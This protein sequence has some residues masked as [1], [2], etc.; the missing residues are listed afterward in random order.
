MI[1]ILLAAL[2]VSI[3]L[4]PAAR[5]QGF[6]SDIKYSINLG[7]GS[8]AI[9]QP[10]EFEENYSPAFGLLL[11]VGVRKGW[12][13]VLADFDFSFFLRKGA[14]P[15][16]LNILNAFLMF[17][18]KPMESKARPYLLFGGGYYRFWIWDLNIFE[19]TTGYAFGAGIEMELNRRQMLF[20]EGKIVNGRT[21][22]TPDRGNIQTIPVRLGISWVI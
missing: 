21:D 10:D 4:S 7:A 13:E 14:V 9:L 2:A 1:R 8:A 17:K 12:I 11:D 6:F 22:L 15:D 18:L 3:A 19:N 20:L 5:A 16:D